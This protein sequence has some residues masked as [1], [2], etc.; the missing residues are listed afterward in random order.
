MQSLN[1]RIKT[2]LKSVVMTSSLQKYRM[3]GQIQPMKVSITPVAS[4]S[5]HWFKASH[6]IR[7]LTSYNKYL[8]FIV[9]HNAWTLR[10]RLKAL[11]LLTLLKLYQFQWTLRH[12][13][14]THANLIL[15]QSLLHGTY[16][17][18]YDQMRYKEVLYR[19]Q[20]KKNRKG[21]NLCAF[22]FGVLFV[23]FFK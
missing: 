19:M 20:D 11:R 23:W 8:V 6:G 22:C 3:T 14:E 12:K 7:V 10:T 4:K 13:G 16:N 17:S 15:S 5:L 18:I 1:R 9:L 2:G 21:N